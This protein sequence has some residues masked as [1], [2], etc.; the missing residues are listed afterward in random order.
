MG[1]RPE[2]EAF[3]ALGALPNEQSDEPL[4]VFQ[5]RLEK[6]TEPVSD[7]E[8]ELLVG[9][10]GPDG[11]FGLAWTLLHLIETAPGGCPIK[12]EPTSS[13]NE[14][15]QTMGGIHVSY[16]S[17]RSGAGIPQSAIS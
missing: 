11:C 2:V 15:V 1:V 8:A 13:D 10:F 7:E 14:W 16:S 9:M 3:V 4:E 6:I 5:E 17:T 12:Q